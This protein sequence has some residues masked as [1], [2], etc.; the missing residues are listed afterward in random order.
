MVA[1]AASSFPFTYLKPFAI[2]TRQFAMLHHVHGLAFF[3]WLGLYVWQTQLAASGRTA[4]HR[5]IGL[6]ALLVSGT[7]LPLGWWMT[8]YAVRV[9]IARGHA[10]PAEFS[11]YNVVDLSLFALC[12]TAAV[13]TVTRHLEWHRRLM[14]AA[15]L[16]L[17]GPAISRWFLPIPEIYPF[18]DLGPNIL[19]DL[20]LIALALHDRKVLGRVH[21]ATIV[22]VLVMVPLHIVEPFIARSDA[23]NQ[24][25]PTLF[26]FD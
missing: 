17:V 7:M 3:S 9:R 26:R 4:R 11:L 5:E 1:M 8:L 21:P 23:W 18:T 13:L 14:F 6:A 22:A 20:F 10:F 25:A 12:V 15:A 19:A 24:I 16:N 2:G